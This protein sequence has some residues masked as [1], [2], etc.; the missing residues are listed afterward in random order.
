MARHRLAYI[1]AFR[2]A[3]TL[4]AAM[5]AYA[6]LEWVRNPELSLVTLGVTHA[7]HVVA[8]GLL[9]YVVLLLGFDRLVGRPLRAIHGHLYRVAL[10]RLDLLDLDTPVEEI[11]KIERSVNLMVRRM[12]LGA[13]DA[14][15][16]RTSLALRDLAARLHDSDPAASDAMLNAAAAL[17]LLAPAEAGAS[18]AR[19]TGRRSFAV[20]TPSAADP[21]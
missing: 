19:P 10:G 8:L 7:A 12:R 9:V 4:A 21:R 16:H 1:L 14:D 20:A 3:A 2:L 5:L 6:V 13:G 11:A 15:P 17:E 18:A